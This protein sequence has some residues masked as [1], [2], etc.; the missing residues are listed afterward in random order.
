MLDIARSALGFDVTAKVG[1][2][3]QHR[4][5]AILTK[6]SWRRGKHDDRGTPYVPS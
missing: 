5:V 1:T 3:D 2:R 4:I 6:L